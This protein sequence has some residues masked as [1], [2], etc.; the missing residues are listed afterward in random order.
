MLQFGRG[1][2]IIQSTNWRKNSSQLDDNDSDPNGD[3]A[4]VVSPPC[5]SCSQRYNIDSMV[6]Q[7]KPKAT[8]SGTA[9]EQTT[10]ENDSKKP[11]SRF[12]ISS[13]HLILASAY[14]EKMLSG[15]RH[16]S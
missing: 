2:W 5:S 8:S 10:T 14:V 6:A 7:T 3:V 9:S 12:R 16:S 1:P 15:H 4:L 11:K 13:K